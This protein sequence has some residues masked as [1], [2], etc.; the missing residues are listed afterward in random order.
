MTGDGLVDLLLYLPLEDIE[1]RGG[2]EITARCPAHE[3]RTGRR[4]QRPRHWSIN[5]LT[6]AHHCFS[7]GYKGSLVRLVMDMTSLG[8]WDAQGL[9]HQF[10]V[11]TTGNTQ[12]VLDLDRL[13]NALTAVE[14][15]DDDYGAFVDPPRRA[16][17]HRGIDPEVCRHFGVRWDPEEPCWILPIRSAKG[18][19]WGW[20][21]KR[22]KDI[23][24]NHPAGVRTGLTLFGLDLL[25]NGHQVVLVESPLDVLVVHQRGHRALAS[26]GAGV[27]EAQL[28]LIRERTDSVILALDN[29]VAGRQ[30]TEGMLFDLPVRFP[31]LRVINY[32]HCPDAKDPGEMSP[33]ELE[34]ALVRAV[35]AT[36]WLIDPS[37]R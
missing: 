28:R 8:L 21:R 9:I 2:K 3:Q 11:D 10:G 36:T 27:T 19:L 1:D 20:Q 17:R 31:D 32:R 29:D 24:L 23:P 25:P 13:A 34:L 4:E 7:C 6:G 18:T 26:F 22:I 16:L 14:G 35:P 30:A 12:P 37:R 33:D 15:L 5:R